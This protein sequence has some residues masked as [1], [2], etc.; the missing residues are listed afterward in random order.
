MFS[1]GSFMCIPSVALFGDS[2]SYGKTANPSKVVAS[3]GPAA[4]DSKFHGQDILPF[5][6]LSA[7]FVY[8]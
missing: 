7:L 6:H 1:C 5:S 3:V 8:R 2:G 4:V